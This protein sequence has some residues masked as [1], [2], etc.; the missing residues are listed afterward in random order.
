MRISYSLRYLIIG[1]IMG[2]GA[3]VGSLILRGAYAGELQP[4]WIAREWD[5]NLG[6][7]LYMAIMMPLMFGIF[8][9]T[10]GQLHDR[11]SQQAKRL[12]ELNL[13]LRYQSMTDGMTECYNHRHMMDELDREIQRSI[14][15]AHPLSGLM[16]DLDNFKGINDKEG[17]L[18]GDAVLREAAR[19]MKIL[20]RRS[21]VL[22][23]YGGDE[24]LIL[25]PETDAQ[26]AHVAAERIRHAFEAH[27]FRM[28]R[29][30]FRS[31]VSIGVCTFEEILHLKA[32]DFIRA[33]DDALI[34]AKQAGKN[35]VMAA[36]AA[37]TRTAPAVTHPKGDK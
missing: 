4:G 28:D 32:S 31:S 23:R 11:T 12:E 1:L 2:A 21:D 9:Y 25:L 7:Y 35:R 8:A 34:Q 18:A 20:I 22:G 36:P 10:L 5:A 24:F 16:I 6:F 19:L 17:H 13:K 14:R 37:A 33:A 30:V 26:S 3:P 27:Q 15:F 29:K